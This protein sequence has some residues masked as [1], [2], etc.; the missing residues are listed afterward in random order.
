MRQE[1]RRQARART[2]AAEQGGSTFEQLAVLV[3]GA[4][5]LLGFLLL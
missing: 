1:D 2:R 4:V 5:A 3:M